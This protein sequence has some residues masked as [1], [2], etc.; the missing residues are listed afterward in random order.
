MSPEIWLG[1]MYWNTHVVIIM[2]HS[3]ITW[4]RV[5]HTLQGI[6]CLAQ[7]VKQMNYGACFVNLWLCDMH[8]CTFALWPAEEDDKASAASD[9]HESGEHRTIYI[10]GLQKHKFCSNAISW[11]LVAQQPHYCSYFSGLSLPLLPVLHELLYRQF[12][13]VSPLTQNE[14]ALLVHPV[15]SCLKTCH[16]T[17]VVVWNPV[18]VPVLHCVE[19][20]NAPALMLFTCRSGMDLLFFLG[21]SIHY[22]CRHLNSDCAGSGDEL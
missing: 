7:S 14:M 5:V 19:C 1:K 6:D 17:S 2:M 15:I 11:V 21:L 16:G 10:N 12:L 13:P 22:F 18:V 9:H 3:G 8:L 20:I 4:K